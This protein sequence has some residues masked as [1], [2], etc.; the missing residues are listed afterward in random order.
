M[1]CGQPK[2]RRG[3]RALAPFAAGAAGAHKADDHDAILNDL[4]RF[5]VVEGK[6]LSVRESGN[7]IYVNFGRRWSEDFTVT[8]AKRHQAGFYIGW[9]RAEIVVRADRAGSRVH[10]GTRRPV[11]R[12][13]ESGAIRD[14]R[15]PIGKEDGCGFGT[16]HRQGT[17][18]GG[19][20]SGACGLFRLLYRRPPDF[21]ARSAEREGRSQHPCRPRASQDSGRLWRRLCQSDA[22]RIRSIAP[23]KSWSPPR[24]GRTCITRSRS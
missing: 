20:G 8:I 7:L 17:G 9:G 22:R 4:G 13:Y 24:S 11:D 15:Q 14:G 19:A 5:A 6:V 10:R 23:S 16:S 12:G 3:I 18:G 2:N 1:R 21:A